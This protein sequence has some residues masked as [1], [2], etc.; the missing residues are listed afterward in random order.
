MLAEHEAYEAVKIITRDYLGTRK[1]G[2]NRFLFGFWM[3]GLVDGYIN[4]KEDKIALEFLHLQMKMCWMSVV[5]RKP[6][7]LSGMRSP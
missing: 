2:E 6:G 7:I 5:S 3:P 4:G 1:V